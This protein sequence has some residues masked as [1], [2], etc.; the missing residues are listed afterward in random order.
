MTW[1]L[2]RLGPPPER[3]AF[4]AFSVAVALAATWVASFDFVPIV[5]HVNLAFH[6]FGHPLFAMF[7]EVMGW[8][9]GTLGQF[10]FPIATTIHFLRREQ[11]LSA[12]ACALWGFENLRYVAWYLADARAQQIPLVGG[13]E[14]DWNYLLGRWGLLEQDARIA[15][16]LVFLSWAGWLA[17]WVVVFLRYRAGA[18]QRAATAEAERRAAIIERARAQATAVR[19]PSSAD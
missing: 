2:E 8:L 6:E 18:A 5:D 12:A 13:G 14:H 17:V 1:S 19:P 3:A 10:I 7:G 15:G 16:M 9:G 11:L 4:I